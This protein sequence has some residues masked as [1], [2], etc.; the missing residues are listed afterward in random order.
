MIRD[1]KHNLRQRP[2]D[3]RF[4]PR[5]NWLKYFRVF[6]ETHGGDPFEFR[7]WLL[8]RDGWRYSNRSYRGP[9]LPPSDEFER[10]RLSAIYWKL[11]LAAVRREIRMLETNLNTFKK[12]KENRSAS[13]QG[14]NP[15]IKENPATNEKKLCRDDKARDANL[16]IAESRLDDLRHWEAECEKMMEQKHEQSRISEI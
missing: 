10:Q 13:L 3:D 6:C 7:G 5:L 11:R 14:F 2:W 1:D 4:L 15:M 12:L 16:L 8:F 9:E